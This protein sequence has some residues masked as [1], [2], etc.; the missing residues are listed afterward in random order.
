M[1]RSLVPLVAVGLLAGFAPGA[2]L[3]SGLEPGK[4]VPVFSPLNVT[5]K[6]AG[7]KQCPV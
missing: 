7:E 4:S 5:G 6:S 2:D 3:K 1:Q